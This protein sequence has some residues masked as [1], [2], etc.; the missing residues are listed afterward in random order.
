MSYS[1]SLRASNKTEAA[2]RIALQLAD[3]VKSQPVHSMDSHVHLRAA[4][5]I[6]DLLPPTTNLTRLVIAMS[7]SLS[8]DYANGGAQDPVLA[9]ITSANLSINVYAES[10]PIE[11]PAESVAATDDMAG[12]PNNND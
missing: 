10:K 3:V 8:Y 6:L 5:E 9:N 4:I 7:G 11:L 2:H 12:L 1:F